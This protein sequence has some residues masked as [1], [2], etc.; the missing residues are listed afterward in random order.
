M[1]ILFIIIFIIVVFSLFI[2]A[3]M[4]LPKFG[5]L[6]SGARQDSI[7]LEPNYING[8]FQNLSPTPQL[9]EGASFFT[10]LKQF[11]F[12]KPKRG[13]PADILPSHKTDLHRLHPDENVLVWFGHSSYFL[14]VDG[15]K[16]LIDPVF[17][18]S[19]SPLPG[20]TKSFPGSDVYSVADIPE[21]DYLLITHDHYDHLDY[22]TIRQLRPKVKKVITSLGVGAHLELWG[23][24]KNII[25]EKAWNEEEMLEPGFKINT[26]PAR[27][28]SGRTFKRNRSLWQSFIL[29]T[30]T[31]K[32]FLGG[33]SGYDTHFCDAGEKFGPFDLVILECGQY[34]KNWRYIHM[35][36][37]EVVQAAKDLKAKLLLPVH[38]GKFQLSLHD[39]DTPI[40]TIT[41]IAKEENMPIITP[42]IGQPV[43]LKEPGIFSPWWENLK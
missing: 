7:E 33:D 18:G 40:I 8:S 6:P 37:D 26:I 14:Q 24:D 28:F 13:K 22:K 43:N 23:Y 3:Y 17:S 5:K 1:F 38:W 39:W 20:G 25:I 9:T 19:A 31:L 36:P 32:L 27:H 4:Q 42:M 2:A 15:R 41:Q 16:M 12:D 10:V 11:V 29:I 30:P 35:L 34:N 21:L